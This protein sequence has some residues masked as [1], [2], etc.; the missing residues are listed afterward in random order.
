VRFGS[1]AAFIY[2]G[3]E[4]DAAQLEVFPDGL[5]TKKK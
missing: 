2:A 3:S 5:K 4:R 1:F